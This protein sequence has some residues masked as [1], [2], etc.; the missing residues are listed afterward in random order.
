MQ[1]VKTDIVTEN[2]NMS[3]YINDFPILKEKVNG[4]KLVYLDNAA[5]THKPQQ[6][7]DK[8]VEFYSKNYSNIHRGVYSLSQKATDLYEGA[9]E[10]VKEFINADNEKEIIF[11]KGATEA[12]NLVAH[13]FGKNLI[14]KDDEIIITEMEHH[15]NIVPWQMIAESKGATLKVIP[16]DE[17]ADLD[18]DVFEKLISDKTKIISLTHISNSLGT[19]NDIKKFITTAHKYDIPVLID[20]SQSVQHIKVDVKE[21]DADFIAFSGHKIYAPTGIGVLYGKKEYLDILPPYQTGGDMIDTVTFQK[22]TFAGLPNK[23][24]AGTPN[25][26]GAVGLAEA[27]NYVDEIGLDRIFKYEK[28]LMDYALQELKKIEG[29]KIYGTP[30]Q[31]ASVI[32]FNIEDI[33]SNDIA[34]MLDLKGVAVRNGQHCTEPLMNRLGTNTTVR[35]SI[36]FYNTKEDIDIFVE[37]LMK[38]VKLIRK[39]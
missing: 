27:L 23:F 24:E 29:I 12:I 22:T 28:E 5:S 30:K 13:S 4:K 32:L 34:T 2:Y 15:A 7:I 10:R 11:T 26:A 17:N 20:A 14:N 9:R 35:A 37:A 38:I 19:I 16:I 36:S 21:L 39:Q 1:E 8:I 6:V 33:H 31:R 25:I 3:K 18:F